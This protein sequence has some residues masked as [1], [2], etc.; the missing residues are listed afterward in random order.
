MLDRLP[1]GPLAYVRLRAESYSPEAR[2]AWRELLER[3]A[4]D[5]P[6]FAFTKHEGV[7]AGD[8]FAGV[9]LAEWLRQAAGSFVKIIFPEGLWRT[10]VT[11]TVTS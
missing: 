4:A 5:R 9:G 11:S 2:D 8:P 10:L 7:P 6:V 3:E 1:E